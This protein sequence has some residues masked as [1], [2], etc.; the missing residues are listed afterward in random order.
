MAT[1]DAVATRAEYAKAFGLRTDLEP[2]DRDLLDALEPA[3]RDVPS[4]DDVARRV[5]GLRDTYPRDAELW[6]LSGYFRWL[7]GDVASSLVATRRATE[8]DPTYADAWQAVASSTITSGGDLAVARGALDRCLG[9]APRSR[10]CLRDRASLDD[11]R[12]DCAAL[13]ADAKAGDF[14][15]QRVAAMYAQR[16][17]P[18]AIDEVLAVPPRSA[19]FRTP[20]ELR[21]RLAFIRGDFPAAEATMRETLS[22]AAGDPNLETHARPTR[23]LVQILVE[24]GRTEDAAKITSDYLRRKDSWLGPPNAATA[25]LL[26]IARAHGDLDEAQWKAENAKLERQGLLSSHRDVGEFWAVTHGFVDDEMSARAAVTE[27][28][29]LGPRPFA[30][31]RNREI[32]QG[33]AGRIL[34]LAG[35]TAEGLALLVKATTRCQGV[36]Y[37]YEQT[38]AWLWLGRAREAT[39]VAGA[40]DAYRIVVERWG[41]ATPRSVSADE[42]RARQK[43]LA[44]R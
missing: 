7:A 37:P 1:P 27:L 13:D 29:A 11:D 39:D 28:D 31:D 36:L 5:E 44:C 15:D 42:A 18:E 8:L 41:K 17:S 32:Y 30:Y 26:G 2:R 38:R 20:A 25:E 43:L 34:V 21:A 6:A 22:A 23:M 12:G 35:R 4:W 33:R 16:A 40:C 10:D 9:I 19:G 14:Q 3:V 24:S